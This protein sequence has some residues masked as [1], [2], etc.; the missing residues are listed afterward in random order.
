[1]A[2]VTPARGRWEIRESLTTPAGP[3][4]RTLATFRTLTPEVVTRAQARS[5]KPLEAKEVLGAALRTGAPVA[6]PPPDQAAR[7]LLKDAMAGQLPRPVLRGLVIDALGGDAPG[8]SDSARAAAMWV[9]ATPEQ[10]AAALRDLLLLADRLPP[11]R[12]DRG[13]R[14][15]RIES[16]PA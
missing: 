8:P 1:M 7:D 2:F 12:S 4:S 14:F 15:P 16:A 10:R 6:P 3:R 5:S 9:A 13:R 11:P